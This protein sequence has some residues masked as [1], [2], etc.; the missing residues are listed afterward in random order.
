MQSWLKRRRGDVRNKRDKQAD[1]LAQAIC[2]IFGFNWS[3]FLHEAV[4]GIPQPKAWAKQAEA[5]KQA[6]TAKSGKKQVKPAKGRK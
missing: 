5:E 3:G 6:K 2:S 1:G 4:K